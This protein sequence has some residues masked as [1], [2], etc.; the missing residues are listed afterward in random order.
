MTVPTGR[1]LPPCG[2]RIQAPKGH[3]F[4]LGGG[5]YPTGGVSAECRGPAQQRAVI[6]FR[7]ELPGRAPPSRRGSLLTRPPDRTGPAGKP[8]GPSRLAAAP[9]RPRRRAGRAGVS[10]PE[11]PAG[12]INSDT[13]RTRA[14]SPRTRR[15]PRDARWAHCRPSRRAG[16]RR[17]HRCRLRIVHRG[18]CR[19]A[20][21]PRSGPGHGRSGRPTHP[22]SR[23]GYSG[24]K[25]DR[26]R[27]RRQ[28]RRRVINPGPGWRPLEAGSDVALR[29][30]GLECLDGGPAAAAEVGNVRAAGGAADAE[31]PGDGRDA[32]LAGLTDLLG[33]Q[34]RGSAEP[35]PA[36]VQ[37]TAHHGAPARGASC[38]RPGPNR[39]RRRR[40][41]GKRP[42]S[43]SR[44]ET[45]V[46]HGRV[47]VHAPVGRLTVR[48][49]SGFPVVDHSDARRPQHR[50][51]LRPAARIRPWVG[52]RD[53]G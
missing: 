20:I 9:G 24:S 21:R 13:V 19:P 45:P 27:I 49:P 31:Q 32:V 39:N 11:P 2:R 30:H 48:D 23:P 6:T 37:P 17:S 15:P 7:L 26:Y 46:R 3:R 35:L 43:S 53:R 8:C 36:S 25:H 10:P 47:I 18:G 34:G 50:P 14:A 40:P 33:G 52:P 5:A 12:A 16:P 1:P 38:R 22:A 44:S 41:P 4:T 28:H 29:S 51:A 42:G